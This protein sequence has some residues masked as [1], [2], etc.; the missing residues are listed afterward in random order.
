MRQVRTPSGTFYVP[1]VPPAD[2]VARVMKDEEWV[3]PAVADV[4]GLSAALGAL[5]PSSA[6]LS[7]LSG[8]GSGTGLVT[9]TG[10]STFAK[11]TLTAGSSK[12]SLTDGNGV[13]GNPTLDVAEA[14]LTLSNL[15]GSIDLS[16]AKASGTLAAGRFPALTGDVTTVAGALASTIANGAVTYA[17]S[18]GLAREIWFIRQR[19]D[20]AAF[21]NNTS[22]QAIF[23][24]TTNGSLSL[25]TGVYLFGCGLYV[26]GMSATSGNAQFNP[27]GNGTAAVAANEILYFAGGTDANTPTN[28]GALVGSMSNQP[29]S[30]ASLLL[31]AV[32]T[33]LGASIMGLMDISTAGTIIPTLALVT[34]VGTAVPKKGCY[35][36]IQY[37]GA[38]G[39]AQV[40]GW[41]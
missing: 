33:G 14:N 31:A 32:G 4:D 3:V 2:G 15:G 1:D 39:T 6:I 9:Q 10:A 35:F 16:G 20:R 27:I 28:A 24:A 21:A 34:A 30:P 13:S 19:A 12:I 23:D 8:M 29:A 7:G 17:K 41:T 25:A 18:S 11:R 5:T 36:W 40:G 37:L 38:T 26:T 22:A